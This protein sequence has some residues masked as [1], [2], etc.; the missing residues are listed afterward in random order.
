MP[1]CLKRGQDRSALPPTP[2][3]II[4]KYITEESACILKCLQIIYCSLI[5]LYCDCFYYFCNVNWPTKLQLN[6][7]VNFNKRL[8]SPKILYNLKF[9]YRQSSHMYKFKVQI[10]SIKYLLV[11]RECTCLHF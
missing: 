2:L 5:C 9:Q 8:L 6:F 10:S 1:G 7:C 11:S 3:Q 4:R